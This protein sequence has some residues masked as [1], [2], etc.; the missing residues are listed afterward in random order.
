MARTYYEVV[1]AGHE[2]AVLCM[3]RLLTLHLDKC[4]A[5]SVAA[6][7][8]QGEHDATGQPTGVRVQCDDGCW[9]EQGV[10]GSEH[11]GRA[12]APDRF[13]ATSPAA[14]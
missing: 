13:A 11:I 9:E 1:P 8:A 14:G 3:S 4:N 2:W 5:V 6:A 10:F 7:V 12:G